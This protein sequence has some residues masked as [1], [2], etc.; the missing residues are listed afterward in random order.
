MTGTTRQLGRDASGDEHVTCSND[1]C[2]DF[3]LKLMECHSEVE[4]KVV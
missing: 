1:T 4:M 2:I 3:A